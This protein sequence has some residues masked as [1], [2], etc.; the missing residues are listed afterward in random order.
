MR[1]DQEIRA[2]VAEVKSFNQFIDE[3]LILLLN[4]D[5][6]IVPHLKD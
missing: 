5:K 6:H 2:V 4:T 1:S 3:R